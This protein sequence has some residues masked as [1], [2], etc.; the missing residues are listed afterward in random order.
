MDASIQARKPLFFTKCPYLGLHEGVSRTSESGFM[1]CIGVPRHQHA[2]V[3]WLC[4]RV[5]CCLLAQI[6]SS[7][8]TDLQGSGHM[9]QF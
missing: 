9:D 6:S 1:N 4:V 2:A 8:V 5:I 3:I 7:I